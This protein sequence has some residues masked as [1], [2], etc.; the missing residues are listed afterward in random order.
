MCPQTQVQFSG[1]DHARLFDVTTAVLH[2]LQTEWQRRLVNIAEH[3]AEKRFVLR[4][5]DTQAGLGHVVAIRHALTQSR[6]L[7]EQVCLNFMQHHV[8]RGGVVDQVMKQQ[9]RQPAIIKRIMGKGDLHQ[10]RLTYVEAVMPRIEALVQLLV[11]RAVCR[12]EVHL[13]DVYLSLTQHHLY[14]FIETFPQH[15]GAQDIVTVDYLLQGMAE[16]V[17]SC[18]VAKTEQSF[19]GVRIAL[20][21][22]DV[23]IENAR[24]QRCQRVNI[25]HVSGTAGHMLHD[26]VDLRLGQADQRQQ[27]RGDVLTM[28]GNQIGRH[29]DFR[30]TTDRC[31]QRRHG[32]LA[33]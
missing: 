12:V 19:Q 13:G 7:T 9:H 33:E 20:I 5:A 8:Q 3:L 25:L 22:T 23:V 24:L 32:R 15:G 31:C 1:E 6:T 27:F 14:R 17:Q 10:G 26:A 30:A 16:I 28:L 4:L 2:I 18:T 29:H 21:G 11:Q